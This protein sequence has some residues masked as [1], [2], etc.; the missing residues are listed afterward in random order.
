[1]KLTYFPARGRPEPA[2]YMLALAGAEFEDNL[3]KQADWPALKPSTVFFFTLLLVGDSFYT[4]V[5][6]ITGYNVVAVSL[7]YLPVAREDW[8]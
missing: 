1:M 3:V 4:I 8:F 6:F 5:S 2:R 7:L